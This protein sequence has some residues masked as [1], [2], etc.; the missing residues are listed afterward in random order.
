MLYMPVSLSGPISPACLPGSKYMYKGRSLVSMW[1]VLT[2]ATGGGNPSR[3]CF[4]WLAAGT[5]AACGWWVMGEEDGT[6][7]VDSDISGLGERGDGSPGEKNGTNLH[8]PF[9]SL[10]NVARP[11]YSV[12]K[13]KQAR[14]VLG[15]GDGTRPTH[16]RRA[17][18]A[19]S[20]LGP[21][22][23]APDGRGVGFVTCH[24]PHDGLLAGWEA[25]MLRRA[26]SG[27]CWF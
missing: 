6:W 14:N 11:R 27:V 20:V 9:L 12:K 25:G 17:A 21:L 26:A 4:C 23:P 22:H 24:L 18:Q 5:C 2:M 15:T 3:V 8:V 16:P 1:E 19:Q 13:Y 10:N 7:A